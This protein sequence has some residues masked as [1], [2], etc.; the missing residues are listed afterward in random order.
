[1]RHPL[2]NLNQRA[3]NPLFFVLLSLTIVVMIVMNSAGSILNT[4][5]APYGIISF[6]FAGNVQRAQAIL[7]S[8]DAA[9]QVHAAFIQGLDFLY[10]AIYSTTIALACLWAGETLKRAT[11]PPVSLGLFLAWGLWFAALCDAL[12][13]FALVKMLFGSISSPWPQIASVC[14]VIKFALIFLGLVYALYALVIRFAIIK[15]SPATKGN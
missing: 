15:K 4:E 5:D 12:E 1:M 13:N 9:A 2:E 7:A 10:L 8:W 14:A 11:W 3:R 6:E